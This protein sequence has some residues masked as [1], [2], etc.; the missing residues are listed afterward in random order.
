M[1]QLSNG[2]IEQLYSN[3]IIEYEGALA[4]VREISFRDPDDDPTTL[5]LKVFG[6]HYLKEVEPDP[7]SIRCPT[8][9]YRL[10]YV[11]YTAESASYLY[12]NPRRQYRVGWCENNVNGLDLGMAQRIPETFLNNLKGLYPTFKEALEQSKRSRGVCAFDRMFAV[13]RGGSVLA[14]KGRDIVMIHDGVPDLDGGNYTNIAPL[15]KM[16]MEK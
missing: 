10:G 5:S 6:E 7:D 8:E 2:D 11:Q 16:A 13:S 1:T 12:R 4:V 9:P 14:Y 15:L 3:C